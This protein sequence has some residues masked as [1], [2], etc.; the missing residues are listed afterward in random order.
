MNEQVEKLLV[1]TSDETFTTVARGVLDDDSA[2]LIGAPNFAEITTSHNDQGTIGILKVSGDARVNSGTEPWS[3][4]VKII[5]LSVVVKSTGAS[6]WVSPE[7]ELL[8]Y[9]NGLFNGESSPLRSAKCYLSD[10]AHNRLIILWLED[11]SNAPQPPWALEHFVSAANHLGKF[12]GD[13][14]ANPTELPFEISSDGYYARWDPSV[15]EG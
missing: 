14:A 5:D 13:L 4:V 6:A 3:S 11:L 10:S 7:I 12:N 2:T 1:N 9:E 8:V 15:V